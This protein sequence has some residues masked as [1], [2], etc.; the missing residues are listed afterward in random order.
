MKSSIATMALL[1]ALAIG[2]VRAQTANGLGATD[3]EAPRI[4]DVVP[5]PVPVDQ[6]KSPAM[7]LP[8]DPIEPYLLTKNDGP[9]MVLAKTF[10]GPD[11]Q[12]M[13]LALVK[14][15]REEYN[16]PAYVLRSK[17]WPGGSNIRN[18]PPQADP[19]VTQASVNV[20][21]KFR[22]LDQA[23]VLV[24]NEKTQKGQ[25]ELHHKVKK[26]KPRCLDNVTTL[27]PWREGL[28]KAIRTTNPYVAAQHLYPAKKDRLIVQMNSGQDSIA[29]CPG[30]YSLQVAEFTGRTTLNEK[31]PN[32][33]G[34][35]NLMRSPLRSAASDAEKMANI[36]RK[37]KEVQALGQPVYVY[38]DR[39]SS[40]VFVG[41][42][43][44]PDDPR[45]LEMR[46]AL[47]K[48]AVPLHT[49]PTRSKT[50]DT[51]IAPALALTDLT[52]IKKHFEP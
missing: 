6:I 17:D 12:R 41:S 31:D 25:V 37:D 26:I 30:T 22:V 4:V 13:A 48:L 1:G 10:Q 29:H 50:L 18:I 40:K 8:D 14:E 47:V 43:N 9:F 45:A 2:P 16:L 38:H 3:S 51:V 24:G 28:S 52:P 39:T 5:E 44:S 34:H 11:A 32:F 33:Q 7:E 46:N 23:A 49:S 20:P 19:S 15:L 21:E 27:F 36:M 35:L 42:F